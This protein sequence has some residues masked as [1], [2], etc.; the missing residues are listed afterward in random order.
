MA[1][2]VDLAQTDSSRAFK[3]SLN[4]RSCYWQ[5]VVWDCILTKVMSQRVECGQNKRCILCCICG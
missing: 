3:L 4:Y 1:N 5:G 2:S